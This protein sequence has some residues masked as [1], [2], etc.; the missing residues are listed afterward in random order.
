MSLEKV[1][2]IASI[3]SSLVIIVIVIQAAIAYKQFKADHER[4]RREKTV[5]LLTEWFASQ[6]KESSVAR[7]I[8]ESLSE[9]QCRD[10]IKERTVSVSN[11]IKKKLIQL[12]DEDDLNIKKGYIHLTEKQTATLRWHISFYLNS[13]EMLLISWQ[14]S[15]VDREIIDLQFAYLFKLSEGREILKEYRIAAGGEDAFPAIEVFVAHLHEK[16]RSKLIQKSKVA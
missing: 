16:R 3:I 10:V 5:D 13:L 14:Y 7:V 2:D 1:A 9:E 12:F 4:G 8:A 11:K 6:T 15:I